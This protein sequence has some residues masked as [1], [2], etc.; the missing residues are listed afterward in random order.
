[1]YLD[2]NFVLTGLFFITAGVLTLISELSA[3]AAAMP[4]LAIH[5]KP[6]AMDALWSA[7]EDF[8]FPPMRK[9]RS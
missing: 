4:A 1:M 5:D 6:P 8:L 9:G 2:R 7:A 3:A